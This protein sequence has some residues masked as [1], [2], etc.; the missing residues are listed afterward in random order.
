MAGRALPDDS[1]KLTDSRI[2][3]LD[4]SN[5]WVPATDE[6]EISLSGGHYIN[7]LYAG[8]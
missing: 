1:S 3:M 8:L 5:E 7:L 2:L 6:K 4:K